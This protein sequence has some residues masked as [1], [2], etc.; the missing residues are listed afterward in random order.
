MNRFWPRR[1]SPEGF[2]IE[3]LANNCRR[4]L[5]HVSFNESE[6][7]STQEV[8]IDKENIFINS[9]RGDDLLTIEISSHWANRDFFEYR[10]AA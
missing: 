7:S 4:K 2:S 1:P 5:S 9:Q 6:E 8:I 10:E 3:K